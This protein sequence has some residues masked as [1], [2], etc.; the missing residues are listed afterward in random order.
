MPKAWRVAKL[1]ARA[2]KAEKVRAAART[3]AVESAKI[4]GLPWPQQNAFV[5]D[6]GTVN[7][8]PVGRPP[9]LEGP[10]KRPLRSIRTGGLAHDDPAYYR[11]KLTPEGERWWSEHDKIY[12][13][14]DGAPPPNIDL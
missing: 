12:Y 5:D 7:H 6:T 8:N 2:A 1:K 11:A 9:M 14:D 3:K 13:T 10:P 4:N